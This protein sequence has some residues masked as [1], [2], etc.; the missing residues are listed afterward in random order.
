M[1]RWLPVA[2]SFGAPLLILLAVVVAQQRQGRE[3]MQSLPAIF[4]GS[5]LIVSRAVG[6]RRHR[7]RLLEALRGVVMTASDRD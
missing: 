2:A 7:T 4:V 5:G 3:R 6:R 1:K